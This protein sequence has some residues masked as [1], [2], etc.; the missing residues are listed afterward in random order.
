MTT[1]SG[2]HIPG[3]CCP[4]NALSC[5]CI[6]ERQLYFLGSFS[7][8]AEGVVYSFL[9]CYWQAWGKWK[10]LTHLKLLKR[11]FCYLTPPGWSK[12]LEASFAFTGSENPVGSRFA[13]GSS[14]RYFWSSSVE[15]GTHHVSLLGLLMA[16]EPWWPSISVRACHLPLNKYSY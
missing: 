1:C 8:E 12:Q 9:R 15:L 14:L 16:V 4:L 10:A 7:F 5:P 11:E 3:H 13:M 6:R 2:E